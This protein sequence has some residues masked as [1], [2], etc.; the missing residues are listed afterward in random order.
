MADFMV[1]LDRALQWAVDTAWGMPLVALLVGGG[2]LLSIVSRLRP[3]L[4]WR[5]AIDILRGKRPPRLVNPE[6]W[7]AYQA[8]F[9]RILGFRP[10]D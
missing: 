9:E 3:L 2:I 4:A 6:V 5:H 1:A 10:E 8:R 7:P